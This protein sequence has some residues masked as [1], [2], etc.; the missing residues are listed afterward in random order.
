MVNVYEMKWLYLKKKKQ[1][2][3]LLEAKI[4]KTKWR[5]GEKN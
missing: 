2:K 3:N 1:S 4:D 5:K